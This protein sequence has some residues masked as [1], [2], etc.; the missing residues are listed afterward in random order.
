MD[1]SG[2]I[3]IIPINSKCIKYKLEIR[4][5]NTNKNYMMLI[6]IIRAISGSIQ[7]VN[8]KKEIT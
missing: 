4:L 3:Q 8:E 1:G 5:I 6:N 7:V 2:E